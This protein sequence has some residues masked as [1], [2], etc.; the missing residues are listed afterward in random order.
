[1]YA[2]QFEYAIG[3][4]LGLN[5]DRRFA[6]KFKDFNPNDYDHLQKAWSILTNFS[7]E[8]TANVYEACTMYPSILWVVD[9]ART[10]DN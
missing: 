4:E 7:D 8:D 2:Y 10:V 3:V 1:M 6:G 5:M 9:E